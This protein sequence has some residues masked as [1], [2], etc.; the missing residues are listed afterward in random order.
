MDRSVKGAV[1]FVEKYENLNQI[2]DVE[3]I[4]S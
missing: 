1:F 3:S 2:H 4:Y